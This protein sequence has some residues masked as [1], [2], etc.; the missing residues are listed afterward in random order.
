[1]SEYTLPDGATTTNEEQYVREWQSTAQRIERALDVT[2]IS[3]NPGFQIADKDGAVTSVPIWLVRKI[4][5]I[6]EERDEAQRDACVNMAMLR[7]RDMYGNG[8]VTRED[9]LQMAKQIAV[10]RGWDCF[11]Q[12]GGA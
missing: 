6:T 10:L 11:K 2:V 7:L 8:F 3:S 9:A 5:G 12:G 1:M 4:I